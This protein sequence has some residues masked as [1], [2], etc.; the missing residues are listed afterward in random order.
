MRQTSIALLFIVCFAG[1]SSKAD[2]LAELKPADYEKTLILIS[3]DG[4]RSDYIDWYDTPN[5]DR[6][7]KEGAWAP[8]GMKPVYPSKTFP[9][10]YS[11]A[12]GLYPANHGIVSN[13]MYDAEMDEVFTIG[14]RDAVTDSRWWGGEPIWVT[15]ENQD[16]KAATYFWV[17][18]ESPV[19][20]VQPSYW[21]VY[22]GRVDGF[23]RVDQ[24]LAW[25][26]L[27][28]EERPGFIS[29]YFSDTDDAGHRYGPESDETAASVLK[30]DGYLG[31]LIDGLQER[32][33]YDAVN[34]VIVSDHGMSELSPDRVIALDDYI[35]MDDVAM[36]DSNPVLGIYP[37]PGKRD[38]LFAALKNAHPNMHVYLAEDVPERFHYTGNDR[39][40]A[41]V[42]HVDDGWSFNRERAWAEANP[43]RFVGGTHGYDNELLS[44]RAVFIAHGPA[45]KDNVTIPSFLNIELYNTMAGIIGVDPAPNDGTAGSLTSIME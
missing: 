13:S 19:K 38:I 28:K 3:F 12:T 44:M 17:G 35:D 34:I 16:V 14:N 33:L 31:R 15:A 41:I 4:F 39:I 1:C 26:E 9:N 23:D 8:E 30:V 20:E 11:I 36:L 32:G 45:F 43:D 40:P 7:I 25:L 22:D 42:G 37:K 5:M 2:R 24:A 27:P 18:S 10:H 21:Y 29:L 6:L